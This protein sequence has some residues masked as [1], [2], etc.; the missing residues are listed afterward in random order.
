MDWGEILELR[1]VDEGHQV[2]SGVEAALDPP[3]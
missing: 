2:N 1:R 3:E